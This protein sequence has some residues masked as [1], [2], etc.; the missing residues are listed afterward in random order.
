MPRKPRNYG[1]FFHVIVRGIGKQILF[2][3]EKDRIKFLDSMRRYRDE[4]KIGI[5]AYCLMEN[6]V[7][8]LIKD[9]DS[10][11]SMFMKKLG[12]SYA[13]Y[14]NKKYERTGHLFQDRYKSEVITGDIDILNVYRYI[15]NN[16]QKAH[17]GRTTTYKWSSYREY[18][19]KGGLTDSTMLKKM[20]GDKS[21]LD[22]FLKSESDYVGMEDVMT[23]HDDVWALQVIKQKLKL[24]SGT[25]LQKLPRAERDEKLVR[26]KSEGLTIRQIERLT[27]ISKSVISRVGQ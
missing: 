16:P 18:G 8:M 14:Y 2:E 23:T 10:N 9:V 27:G 25:E 21:R 3:D 19:Q 1:Q 13:A 22:D 15:L 20:I 11:L 4:T 7:H 5:L 6:H 12:I 17:I 24:K 26:L